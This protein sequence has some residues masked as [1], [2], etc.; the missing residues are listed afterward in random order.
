MHSLPKNAPHAYV[1]A[2]PW[3]KFR[4]K[5]VG[6]REIGHKEVF[7]PW[8]KENAALAEVAATSAG[9][10]GAFA[11]G[12]AP[13]RAPAVA[14]SRRQF[15]SYAL[16]D[17]MPHQGAVDALGPVNLLSERRQERR[18]AP[19]PNKSDEPV[20][21]LRWNPRSGATD[22]SKPRESESLPP[23]SDTASVSMSRRRAM[24]QRMV[25]QEERE[26]R[27]AAEAAARLEKTAAKAAAARALHAV[28]AAPDPAERRGRSEAAQRHEMRK[29]V[30]AQE[31]ERQRREVEATPTL[32]DYTR[33]GGAAAASGQALPLAAVARTH[34]EHAI[35]SDDAKVAALS[36]A[37]VVKALDQALN[38]GNRLM[39]EQYKGR[40][41]TRVSAERRF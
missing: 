24:A 39:A 15:G 26:A 41:T 38:A 19:L 29:L 31:E 35:L 25:E 27:T 21:T 18:P 33:P 34:A 20:D 8:H 9:A 22:G 6:R 16:T 5:A 37:R 3:T 36:D 10:I 12:A 40:N 11:P 13:Q 7:R 32:A 28:P 23:P 2:Q 30:R 14:T 1:H 17:E 4:G